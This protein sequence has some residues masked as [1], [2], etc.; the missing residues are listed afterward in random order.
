MGEVPGI[1]NIFFKKQLLWGIQAR[2]M[3]TKEGLDWRFLDR[4][5]RSDILQR[6]SKFLL[7]PCVLFV[8]KFSVR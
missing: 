8:V 7:S 2:E 4:M 5:Y 3:I 1:A 6:D